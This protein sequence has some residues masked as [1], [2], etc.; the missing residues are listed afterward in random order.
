LWLEIFPGQLMREKL[1]DGRA[2]LSL[3]SSRVRKDQLWCVWAISEL[4]GLCQCETR[5]AIEAA[6]AVIA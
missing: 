1:G 5:L 2:E 3:V 6:H 4:S